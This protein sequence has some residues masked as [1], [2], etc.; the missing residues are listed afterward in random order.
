M[1]G[2]KIEIKV[3]EL[4]E[5]QKK[6]NQTWQWNRERQ[7]MFKDMQLFSMIGQMEA[8]GFDI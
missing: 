3:Q 6:T 1:E 8:I 7:I 2:W 4:C 5:K